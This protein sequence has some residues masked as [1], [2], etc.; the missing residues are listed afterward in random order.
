MAV[1]K[2][3][4]PLMV[5]LLCN[6]QAECFGETKSDTLIIAQVGAVI[7]CRLSPH[8]NCVVSISHL[9]TWHS[10]NSTLLREALGTAGAQ[11]PCWGALPGASP[12][13]AQ[14]QSH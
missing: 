9:Y 14:R 6:R 3:Y 10:P 13:V 11:A 7:F 12:A 8:R 4:V 2:A 5:N 1:N